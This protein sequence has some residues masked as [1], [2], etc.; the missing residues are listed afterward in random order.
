MA[1]QDDKP[2][3]AKSSTVPI[4]KI[5]FGILILLSDCSRLA[6]LGEG[7]TPQPMRSQAEF[8]GFALSTFLL[9]V[10]L[11]IWLIASASKQL[12]RAS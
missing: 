8:L 12:R 4:L 5:F 2:A 9:G 1:A 11:P 3:P 6:K 10:V 7:G